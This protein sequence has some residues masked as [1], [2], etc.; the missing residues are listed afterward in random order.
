MKRQHEQS[1]K[2]CNV[3]K[4]VFNKETSLCNFRIRVSQIQR[5][6]SQPQNILT[7]AVPQHKDSA[8]AHRQCPNTRTM[9]QHIDSATAHRQCHNTRTVPQH[10][11]SATAHR[12]CHNTRTVPQHKDTAITQGQCHY[13]GTVPRHRCVPLLRISA[14]PS[15]VTKYASNFPSLMTVLPLGMKSDNNITKHY[16]NKQ[17]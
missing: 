4:I 3:A 2:C 14:F 15:H 5:R 17:A 12:Q 13:T 8:T 1:E 9:P 6:N 16:N 7:A 10:K 11:D